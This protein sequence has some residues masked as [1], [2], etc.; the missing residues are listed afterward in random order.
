M[1]FRSRGF[2]EA[3]VTEVANWIADILDA[4]GAE[5]AVNRTRAKVDEIC[6]KFPVYAA[7]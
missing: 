7:E 1:L 3:E 5:E 4:N 2:K 6:R